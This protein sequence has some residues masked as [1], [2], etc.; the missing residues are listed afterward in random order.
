MN[1]KILDI[2]DWRHPFDVPGL[3]LEKSWY[4]EWHPWRLSVEMPIMEKIVGGL[5]GK[6]ILD[7]GCNDG[8][9]G[10]EFEKRGAH[11]V[12]V[13]ARQAAIDRAHLMKGH[14]GYQAD[15]LCG[16]LQELSFSEPVLKDPFDAVLFYGLL[17]HLSDPIGSLRKVGAMTKRVI[18]VQTFMNGAERRPCLQIIDEPTHLPGMGTTAIVTTPSQAAVVKMLKYAGFDHVYRAVAKPYLADKLVPGSCPSWQFAFFYGVK[19]EP[20]S[21]DGL[22]EITENSLPLNPYGLVARSFDSIKVSAKRMIRGL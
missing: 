12:L 4:A 21:V 10:Y 20:V 13:D 8:F 17:Y 22:V 1:S 2:K 3:T 19:G 18:S 15:I 9:Y 6:R 5:A 16:D 7:I 14:F 11:A